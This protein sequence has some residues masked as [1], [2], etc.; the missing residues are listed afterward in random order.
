M[1]ALLVISLALCIQSNNSYE[2]TIS[3]SNGGELGKWGTMERCAPGTVAKGFSLKVQ[4]LQGLDDD[5]ALNGI[6]LHCVRCQ[7]PHLK[8]N[9]SSTLERWGAWTA[10][11]W[12]P[13]G[14]LVQFSL[15]VEPPQGKGDDTGANN[16]MFRCSD[17]SVLEGDGLK[18]GD[19]GKWSEKC[20]FGV[21]GIRTRVEEN[22][23]AGDDTALNDVQ[24]ECCECNDTPISKVY[25]EYI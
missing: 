16:I 21:C 19:Y 20:E 8:T 18:Y 24:F 5:T 25:N 10:T 22:Q 11:K 17:E 9:I 15:R 2:L 3:V 7:Y 23:D 12:C 4:P 1:L 6:R 13:Y 14:F